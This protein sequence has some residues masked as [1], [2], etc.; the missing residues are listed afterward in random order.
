MHGLPWHRGRSCQLDVLVAVGIIFL[1]KNQ[2]F[3]VLII[4]GTIF[5]AKNKIFARI[6]C[7]DNKLDKYM[8]PCETTGKKRGTCMLHTASA[9]YIA[10]YA[11]YRFHVMFFI[12]IYIYI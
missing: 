7:T 5:L 10:Y 8:L 4:V 3:D 9:K 11:V 6:S 1:A 2:S 12:Y